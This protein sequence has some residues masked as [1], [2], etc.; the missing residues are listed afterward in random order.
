MSRIALSFERTRKTRRRKCRNLHRFRWDG[1]DSFPPSSGESSLP[2]FTASQKQNTRSMPHPCGNPT[3]LEGIRHVTGPYGPSDRKETEWRTISLRGRK[4][5]S[6]RGSV[7]FV[8]SIDTFSNGDLEPSSEGIDPWVLGKTLS[9]K[10]RVG[11][12]T[13]LVT[14][15]PHRSN[16]KGLPSPASGLDDRRLARKRGGTSSVVHWV[17]VCVSVCG[18][19]SN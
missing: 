19:G 11:K 5:R 1:I 10:D 9:E 6:S 2:V 8:R 14:P 15:C 12:T 16:E 17:I 13:I 18:M 4:G 7:G 3:V